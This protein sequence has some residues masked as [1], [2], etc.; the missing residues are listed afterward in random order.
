MCHVDHRADR[1]PAELPG[2]VCASGVI[3]A[4]AAPD[5]SQT[6]SASTLGLHC[7]PSATLAPLALLLRPP[8]S[9]C[10]LLPRC[11]FARCTPH[12]KRDSMPARLYIRFPYL[13]PIP[14]PHSRHSIDCAEGKIDRI[15]NSSV[16]DL[17]ALPSG[18]F[19]GRSGLVIC[20]FIQLAPRVVCSFLVQVGIQRAGDEVTHS[21]SII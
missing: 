16:R 2:I 14:A 9:C 3:T 19:I 6:I 15:I 1:N 11:S 5:P 12:C 17:E 8:I 4:P 13:A 7:T 21:D 18:Q 20:T 10:I